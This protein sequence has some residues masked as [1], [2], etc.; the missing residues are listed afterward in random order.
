MT[1]SK[2]HFLVV[3]LL[4]IVFLSGLHGLGRE[5]LCLDE[6][7]SLTTASQPTAVKT[8][9][10]AK[11]A[12]RNPPLHFLLLHFVIKLFGNSEFALRLPSVIFFVLS[13]WMLYKIGSL[14]DKKEIAL[15]AVVIAALSPYLREFISLAR[16]Y[17]LL[18]FL[19]LSSIYCLLSLWKKPSKIVWIFYVVS[20]L[21]MLY[22]HPYGVIYLITNNLIFVWLRLTTNSRSPSWIHWIIAQVIIVVLVIPWIIV[23]L[24][25]IEII[26]DNPTMLTKPF[27]VDIPGSIKTYSGGNTIIALV[28]LLLASLSIGRIVL[29]G[30]CN[31]DKI[32][33]Q[34]SYGKAVRFEWTQLSPLGAVAIWLLAPVLISFVISHISIPIFS[35]RYTIASSYAYYLLIALGISVFTRKS[36]RYTLLCLIAA[37]MIIP[38]CSKY[39]MR[40]IEQWRDAA[41]QIEAEAIDGDAIVFYAR[42]CQTPYNYYASR[43]DLAI[44]GIPQKGYSHHIDREV[45]D[46]FFSTIQEHKRI[47]V[48]FSHSRYEDEVRKYLLQVFD[49]TQQNDY[50]KI[51]VCLMTPKATNAD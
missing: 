3:F 34:K 1:D 10:M 6:S 21:L 38:L 51:K 15:L 14:I 49:I 48:V 24:S 11:K 8:L 27:F 42:Y 37:M 2:I 13:L 20:S 19:T 7:A 44:Y 39:H 4:G 16:V 17:A 28:G 43:D 31:S 40:N 47:W 9:Q 45:M 46:I 33:T 18:S 36:V 41:Q 35:H 30:S 26:H 50:R 29:F 23:H 25:V 12:N 22:S 32:D 5:S